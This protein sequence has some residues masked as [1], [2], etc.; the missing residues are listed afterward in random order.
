M[1]NIIARG[2]NAYQKYI[3]DESP[4]REITRQNRGECK[5]S[6]LEEDWKGSVIFGLVN[7][8]VLT[9]FI[10]IWLIKLI[11]DIIIYGYV[12]YS[13]YGCR[14]YLLTAIWNSVIFFSILTNQSR[15]GKGTKRRK[16]NNLKPFQC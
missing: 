14:I 8:S 5:N 2:D 7:A 11:I 4:G 10:I 13:I 1:L 3:D 6:A 15:Q 12:L 9:V 16:S